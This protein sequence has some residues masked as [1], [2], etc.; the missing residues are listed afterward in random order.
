M[1][2]LTTL[3]FAAV[4]LAPC[5]VSAQTPAAAART[6]AAGPQWLAPDAEAEKALHDGLAAAKNSHKRLAVL[7]EGSWCTLCDD[8]HQAIHNDP[9]LPHLLTGYVGLP[10]NVADA[11]AVQQFAQKIHANLPKDNAMLITVLDSDGALL[12]AITAPRILEAGHIAP[13]KL[14]RILME[15]FPGAPAAEVFAQSLPAL[16]A[17]GRLGWVEFRADWCGWCKKMEKFFQESEA[18]PILAKYY[19]VVTVDTEKNEGSEPLA[20]RLG[21]K[22]GIDGIPWFAVIDAQGKVLATSEGPKGNIGFPD[23][24]I[25]VA[26]FFSVL[27]STAKGITAGEIETITKALKAK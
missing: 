5:L 23:S 19:S 25:E 4:I 15:F 27:H 18:A 10:I 7:Y 3:V 16:A 2:L 13:A 20:R 9:D 26:H 22:D 8:V 17:G 1:K 11:A 14:N 21:S 24:D 12:T 6:R